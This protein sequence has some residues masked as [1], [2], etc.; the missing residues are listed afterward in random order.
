MRVAIVGGT[1]PFGRALARR[2]QAAG[3]DVVLG[4]RDRARAVAAAAELGVEGAVNEESVRGVELVV[5]A[6]NAAAMLETLLGSCEHL[7]LTSSHNPRALPPPTLQSLARQLHGP[8]S[9]IIRDP[10]RAVA[11]AR[12]LAGA[13][14]VVLA[15]GSIYLVADLLAPAGRRRA[16]AACISS[17]RSRTS[18]RYSGGRTIM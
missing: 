18:L 10:H 7:V 17:S 13:S 2:L 1:G 9:E 8:P 14:G 4:S 6:T 3:D 11:R 5:L 16:S 15:T 12:E